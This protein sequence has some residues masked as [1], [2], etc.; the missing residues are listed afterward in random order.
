MKT[1]NMATK[2]P[3]QHLIAK[4]QNSELG[5]IHIG[6]PRDNIRI[7]P[8]LVDAITDSDLWG[9]AKKNELKHS[10]DVLSH[11]AGSGFSETLVMR[12][13]MDNGLIVR[14]W[15]FVDPWISGNKQLWNR[16]V[17]VIYDYVGI[18]PTYFKDWESFDREIITANSSDSSE[19]STDNTPM[20]SVSVHARDDLLDSTNGS[21]MHNILESLAGNISLSILGHNNLNMLMSYRGSNLVKKGSNVHNT[22]MV[23]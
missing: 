22:V 7:I 12:A 4:W 17:H 3:T 19:A 16:L 15:Y 6:N 13:L 11:G 5:M 21:I 20:I 10:V 14:N 9:Y 2:P 18:K 23:T 8:N 1:E